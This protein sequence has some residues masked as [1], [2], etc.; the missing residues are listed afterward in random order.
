MLFYLEKNVQVSETDFMLSLTGKHWEISSLLLDQ[1][2]NLEYVNSLGVSFLHVT[3]IDNKYSLS[4]RL[5]VKCP[6]LVQLK[7]NFLLDQHLGPLNLP[8]SVCQ[9]V[10]LSYF[11]P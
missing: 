6:Q 4:E 3:V 5:M 7:V 1:K 2:F 11:P 10:E 9:S 8:L